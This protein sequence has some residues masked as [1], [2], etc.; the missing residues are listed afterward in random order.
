WQDFSTR[1]TVDIYID[2]MQA[3]A[4]NLRNTEDK[5]D[6]LPSDL[7]VRGSSIGGGRLALDGKLNIL[8]QI[9]DFDL[10][11]KLEGIDLPAMNTY[12]RPFAGIDFEKGR[13]DIYSEL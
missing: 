7:T 8:R 1:P 12:A 3:R 13:L 2:D 10:A 9:P 4:T 5:N 11:G 6:A